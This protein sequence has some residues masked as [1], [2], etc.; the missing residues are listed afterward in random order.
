MFNI[1]KSNIMT[2]N[3]SCYILIKENLIFY[4]IGIVLAMPNLSLLVTNIRA[5]NS[6][7]DILY[8]LFFLF[9]F[10]RYIVFLI[11]GTHNQY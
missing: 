9:L 6:I 1:N 5:K 7:Y 3:V 8:S 11:N 2:T 4:I 10:G